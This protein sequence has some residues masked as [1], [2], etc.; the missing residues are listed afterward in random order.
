[1]IEVIGGV[2]P[3]TRR[4]RSSGC[5][6][7]ASADRPPRCRRRRSGMR[8]RMSAHGAR[9]RAEPPAAPLRR[10]P[11]VCGAAFPLWGCPVRY[12]RPPTEAPAARG[13][14]ARENTPSTGSS[15]PGYLAASARR[16][17]V[18]GGRWS[19]RLPSEVSRWISLTSPTSWCSPPTCLFCFPF[20][21]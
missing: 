7:G 15:P 21:R 9:N 1:M 6:T 10:C 8:R 16:G 20:N 11:S 19:S 3:W 2:S 12:R 4:P 13:R 18:R 5:G 17:V 14:R